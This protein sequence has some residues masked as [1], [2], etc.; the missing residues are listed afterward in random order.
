M[1]KR[2]SVL[3]RYAAHRFRA[4]LIVQLQALATKDA[5]SLPGDLVKYVRA[6]MID[7]E[8]VTDLPQL[9]TAAKSLWTR[10]LQLVRKSGLEALS[11]SRNILC[12]LGELL[13]NAPPSSDND[14]DTANAKL[15]DV[16]NYSKVLA[17]IQTLT[18][19][20]ERRS[21]TAM[22][23]YEKLETS[24]KLPQLDANPSLDIVESALTALD[25]A[26]L[27]APL[28]VTGAVLDEVAALRK[29]TGELYNR[30]FRL[31]NGKPIAAKL[32]EVRAHLASLVEAKASSDLIRA[33]LPYFN[34][35]DMNHFCE[36]LR[37]L[38]VP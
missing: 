32:K 9:R 29:H 4:V 25:R 21:E 24:S 19:T 31:V 36:M 30:L 28:A 1:D 16:P 34:E 5:Q 33:L 35:V 22:W 2:A 18:E 6:T 27:K 7:S 12:V 3:L 13:D 10:N 17:A 20:H 15:G 8:A 37:G 11:A 23:L 26:V 14:E 38:Y